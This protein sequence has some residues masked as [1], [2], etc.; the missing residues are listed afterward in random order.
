MYRFACHRFACHRFA[1]H[2]F[3]Y[4]SFACHRFACHGFVS[5]R[6]V[7][8]KF[9]SHNLTGSHLIGLHVTGLYR[10]GVHLTG[11]H[12]SQARTRIVSPADTFRWKRLPTICHFRKVRSTS[13]AH[14][15]AAAYV[16]ICAAFSWHRYSFVRGRNIKS[17]SSCFSS[18]CDPFFLSSLIRQSLSRRT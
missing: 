17:E 9:A 14:S 6:L 3:A 10:T 11:I 1:C 16:A 4:H 12:L 13:R 5:H 15:A 18:L 8:Y 2:R 7:S